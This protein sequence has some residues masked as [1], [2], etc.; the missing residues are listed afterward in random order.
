MAKVYHLNM[1]CIFL[2]Q[3]WR[4]NAE[5]KLENK[6]RRWKYYD[7]N[8]T[9]DPNDSKEGFIEIHNLG[10]VLFL[11]D[12][13]TKEVGFE[14][15]NASLLASQTWKLG[16]KQKDGWRT[17]IHNNGYFL[18]LRLKIGGKGTILKLEDKGKV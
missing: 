8:T 4:F 6:L 7:K 14:E 12:E 15:R 11:K 1:F 18:T 3:L 16:K 9:F 10:K 5:G 2:A 17:I 13:A